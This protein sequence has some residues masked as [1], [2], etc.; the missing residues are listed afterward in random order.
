MARSKSRSDNQR[1]FATVPDVGVQRSSFDRSHGRKQTIPD[2][3]LLIPIFVDEALPGDTMSVSLTTVLRMATPRYPL[4]DNVFADVHFF[5]VPYRLVWNHAVN[6]FGEKETPDDETEYLIP[7]TTSP[8]STGYAF[9]SL[10]DYLEIPPG[11]P[12]LEHSSLFHRA[13]N[14]IWNEWYR[15]QNLQDPVVVDMDDTSDDPAD[16]VLLPRGKRHDYFT[17][18]L[19]WPQKGDAVT[20]GIGATAPVT[21]DQATWDVRNQFNTPTFQ[22]SGGGA[23]GPLN[24]AGGGAVTHAA[25]FPGTLG[26]V[27]DGLDVDTSGLTFTADL[28]VATAVTINQ[29]RLALQLQSILEMDARGG[30]RYTEVI[31]SQFKVTSS[32]ARLQRAELLGGGTTP[33]QVRPV[34]SNTEISAISGGTGNN[35]RVGSLGAYGIGVHKGIGFSKSFEEHSIVIG[36]LSIR[37]D[38]NYQQGLPRMYSRSTRFDHYWP[39][40]ANL[41][42]Q[43][44]LNRELYA[45]GTTEDDDVFGYQ[46]RWAEYR[47][48]PSAIC[49]KFRST[50][51]TPLDAWHLAQEFDSLPALNSEFIEENPPLSRVMTVPSESHW[52]MDAYF[53]FRHARPMPTHSVPGVGR[54][55]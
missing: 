12:D 55:L 19:P 39:M 42:E 13:Y 34:L 29:L 40:L 44:V 30:T 2:E 41:G 33:V 9:E 3:G 38:L 23:A 48:K 6:F 18:C 22:S 53:T 16:Y 36:L 1:S 26:W 5:A 31:R 46:E 27:S 35:P 15:D 45:Q 10:Q 47:Y 11:V 32:D 25:G 14:R 54:R 24:V 50:H 37:A 51:A 7:T 4:M 43:S 17:S 49:G 20:I 21:P 28:S 8:A 52:L